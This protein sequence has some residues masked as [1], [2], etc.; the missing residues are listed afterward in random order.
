MSGTLNPASPAWTLQKTTVSEASTGATVTEVWAGPKSTQD[1]WTATKV[2]G[3]AHATYTTARLRRKE[4]DADPSQT[5]G[6]VSLIYDP[7][8]TASDMPPSGTDSLE[9]SEETY[10]EEVD[11]NP[12]TPSEGKKTVEGTQYVYRR[13]MVDAGNIDIATISALTLTGTAARPPGE[14]GGTAWTSKAESARKENGVREIVTRH[15]YRP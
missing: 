3:T 9:F 7:P 4:Y 2:F 10:T 11:V 12:L 1:T 14:S 6:S 5:M 13:T 8:E 15:V